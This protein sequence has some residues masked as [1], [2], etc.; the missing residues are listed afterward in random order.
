MK[1]D[2][3]AGGSSGNCIAIRSSESTILI[4][5]GIAKT[6]IEKK[7]LDA[8][9]RPDSIEAI[10]VTHA[11]SDHIKGLPLANKY[12]VPVFAA[13][14]EWKS[15][16]GVDISLTHYI[17]DGET[18]PW[19]DIEVA[20]FRVHHD[21]FD[22]RGYTVRIGDK[23][24]AICLDTGH[25]DK[26][27]LNA[28]KG[29]DIYVIEAN[30]EPAMVEYSDYPDKVKARIISDIGHLSNQQTAAALSKL[31]TGSGEKIIITHLS[32]KNN[33]PEIAKLTIIKALSKKGLKCN[34]DYEL[35][36]F[37]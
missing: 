37:K 20:S 17:D 13:K 33:L 7:L 5:A 11:H 31:V 34:V 16:L 4:D 35:Q 10:F 36:V 24:A 25:I 6:K 26:D 32:S 12:R 3:L 27:I 15:I 30:H 2:I 9:I 1:V 28:M 18:I 14:D 19:K 22:P 21:A 23:K 8:G 29:S